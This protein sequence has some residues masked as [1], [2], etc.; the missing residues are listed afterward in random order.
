MTVSWTVTSSPSWK[1]SADSTNTPPK[2]I[3]PTRRG[4]GKRARDR[5]ASRAAAAGGGASARLWAPSSSSRVVG[6]CL[7]HAVLSSRK[8]QTFCRCF[9]FS[10][11]SRNYVDKKLSLPRRTTAHL[12]FF[13]KKG[14]DTCDT[15]CC[16][17]HF[18]AAY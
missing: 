2:I 10:W 15:R 13:S 8:N 3:F 5:I 1:Q 11:E 4:C 17:P 7:R 14:R 16:A 12:I 6:E 9:Y 18:P